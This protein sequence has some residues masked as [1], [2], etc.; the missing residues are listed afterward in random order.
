MIKIIYISK[1]KFKNDRNYIWYEL[2]NL[3]RNWL[4]LQGDK[5][6]A[7]SVIFYTYIIVICYF[8]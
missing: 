6:I 5:K 8:N 1:I 7:D 4:Y 3:L 2:Y